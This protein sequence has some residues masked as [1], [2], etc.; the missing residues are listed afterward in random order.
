M[1]VQSLR[2]GNFFETQS[3]HEEESRV[4][5]ITEISKKQVHTES[6]WIN[7]SDVIAINITEDI[8]LNAGFK[9]FSWLKD[10]SVFECDHF[11]CTLDGNGINL[12][13]D[14]LKNLKPVKH[15]HQ[16]QNLY[17]DLTGEE[18]AIS[19]SDIKSTKNEMA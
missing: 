17:Y 19:L 16:L 14:S 2:I 6:K 11:K 5:K 9:R 12:F 8:L 10:Y 7:L 15:L 18:L 3:L 4:R 1:E 13:G